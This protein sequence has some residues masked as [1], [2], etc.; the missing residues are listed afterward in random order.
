MTL[1]VTVYIKLRKYFEFSGE[2]NDCVRLRTQASI[3]QLV[4][5]PFVRQLADAFRRLRERV[6]L[7]GSIYIRLNEKTFDLH[8]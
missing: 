4:K 1:T 3:D 2:K 6:T 5:G 7:S 8:A